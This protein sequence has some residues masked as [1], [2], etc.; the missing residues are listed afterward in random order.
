MIATPLTAPQ[1]RALGL[2]LRGPLTGP[3]LRNLL[4]VDR[5]DAAKFSRHVARLIRA[6]HVAVQVLEDDPRRKR[7]Y[8]A[9]EQGRAA[10]AATFDATLREMPESATPAPRDCDGILADGES[11]AE[12]TAA[13]ASLDGLLAGCKRF[14][15][16]DRYQ[17]LS[18]A[19]ERLSTALAALTAPAG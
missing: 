11:V 14:L 5:G 3:E 18:A 19:K 6:G 9:T 15:P 13:Y 16:P 1:A 17:E 4:D 7:L 12:L 8:T 2:L 10:F